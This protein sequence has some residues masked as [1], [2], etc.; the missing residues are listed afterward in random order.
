MVGDDR[1]GRDVRDTGE[2]DPTILRLPNTL[3][4]RICYRIE[5]GQK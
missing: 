3:L 4:I 2:G 5:H 1:E